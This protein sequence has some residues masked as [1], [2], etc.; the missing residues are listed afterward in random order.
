MLYSRFLLFIYI[1]VCICQ[2]QSTSL[3]PFPLGNHVCF[4]HLWLY[5][6]VGK[7][8][9]V[10]DSLCYI[11]KLIQLFKS[12]LILK[13]VLNESLFVKDK[14]L[15]AGFL[16]QLQ[17]TLCA[18]QPDTGVFILQGPEIPIRI[19]RPVVFSFS[20]AKEAAYKQLQ[21]CTIISVLCG[22]SSLGL[23]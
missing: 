18:R 12:T 6:R 1:V 17:S 4:L 13:N 15:V 2:S 8:I 5:K 11:Q 23:D 16:G 19:K 9:R 14:P 20:L 22:L 21:I 3:S 7:C 10:T